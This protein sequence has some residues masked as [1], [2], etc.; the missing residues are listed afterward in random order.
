MRIDFIERTLYVHTSFCTLTLLN[1]I[2]G[3]AYAGK[4]VHRVRP[5]PVRSERRATR[6]P[7]ALFGAQ[8]ALGFDDRGEVG[9]EDIFTA[10]NGAGNRAGDDAD[11]QEV[12]LRL[13]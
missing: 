13:W 11:R 8:R 5:S 9:W 6:L 7:E 1:S 12:R 4:S 10:A 3:G 2:H